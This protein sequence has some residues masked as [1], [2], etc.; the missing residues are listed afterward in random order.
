M[1]TDRIISIIS[2]V[3]GVIFSIIPEMNAKL[4][5]KY[6]V[7]ARLYIL[8]MFLIPSIILFASGNRNMAIIIFVA[9]LLLLFII[10]VF[11]RKLKILRN[12]YVKLLCCSIEQLR[13]KD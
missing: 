13:N 2:F 11:K 5:E 1:T 10:F 9:L 4:K 12:I 6:S 3:I 7:C 8:I